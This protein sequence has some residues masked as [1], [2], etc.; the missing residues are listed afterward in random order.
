MLQ[1]KGGKEI[2]RNFLSMVF[3]TV[4]ITKGVGNASSISAD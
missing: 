2:A 4:T 1:T 3:N